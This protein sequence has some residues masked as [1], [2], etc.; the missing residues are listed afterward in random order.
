MPA[1]A[2]RKYVDMDDPS[3][4]MN[5]WPMRLQQLRGAVRHAGRARRG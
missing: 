5:A 2:T 4:A 3:I 1:S